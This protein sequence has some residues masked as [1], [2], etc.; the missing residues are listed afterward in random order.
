MNPLVFQHEAMATTCEIRIADQAPAYARQ[1]AAAAFRELDRLESEL[2]RYVE[3]SDIARANRL[4]PGETIA[5]GEDAVQCLLVAAE[6]S[7][8]T[9]RAFDPAYA[10]TADPGAA[11]DAP[12]FTLDPG[13]HTITSHAA[14]L[15]LDLGAV[16][17]G[18]ALDQMAHVLAEW[19]IT[20]A[21]L[22]SGGSTA[23]ALAAP[24]DAPGWPVSLGGDE[25]PRILHLAGASLS[26]SGTAV[27]GSHLLD[28]R[29]GR[30]VLRPGRVWALA[31]NAAMSDALSTAFF[32]MADTE[33]AAFCAAHPEVGAALQLPDGQLSCFGTLGSNNLE[34]SC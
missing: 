4:A 30:P 1:A 24:A 32:I 18:Y 6:L 2:S 14:R 10:S 27:K 25:A 19:G 3:S 23:L 26:G 16:G 17:K 15:H 13:A 21:C 7:A 34:P 28:P 29:S 5:I 11:P 9:A 12:L 31:S 8:A 20:S 33:V 22:Q